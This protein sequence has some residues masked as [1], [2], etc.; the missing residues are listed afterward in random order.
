MLKRFWRGNRVWLA[1]LAS[2]LGVSWWIGGSKER[3]LLAVPLMAVAVWV[4]L[5]RPL[6]LNLTQGEELT[7]EFPP[8]R[9]DR[10]IPFTTRCSKM[11]FYS[12]L[13]P[14]ELWQAIE[15]ALAAGNEELSRWH[16][17]P[18]TNVFWKKTWKSRHDGNRWALQLLRTTKE[19]ASGTDAQIS[20]DI[21]RRSAGVS[22]WSWLSFVWRREHGAVFEGRVEPWETGSVLCGH[23][24][25]GPLIGR[26]LIP[27]LWLGVA[28]FS[29]LWAEQLALAFV[30]ALIGAHCVL[31]PLGRGIGGSAELT[32]ETQE[33]LLDFFGEPERFE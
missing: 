18:G 19:T 29:A 5:I 15:T 2:Y 9:M 6:W 31:D 27:A 14:E 33:A 8:E 13:P 23:F 28:L 7:E 32:L 24:S 17:E 20:A 22:L 21:G 25:A 11:R 12:D 3:G 16:R 30:S 10:P 26:L 4:L 1:G